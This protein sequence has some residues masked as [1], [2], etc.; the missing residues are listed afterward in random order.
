MDWVELD[1]AGP[2]AP[3]GLAP[4]VLAAGVFALAFVVG[5]S[6]PAALAWSAGVAVAQAVWFAVDPFAT[7]HASGELV[8]L[9]L[10]SAAVVAASFRRV[11]L[12]PMLFLLGLLFKGAALFHPSHWYPD[13]RLHRRYVEAF[14]AAE[15][16]LL[17]RGI[18]AQIAS[19]TAYA[20]ELAGKGYAFPYSPLFYVPFAALDQDARELERTMK[21]AGLLMAAVELPLVYL[22]A[23]SVLGAGAA[24]W[25]AGLVWFLPPVASRMLYAQW[26]TLAGHLIDLLL[27]AAALALAR[28]P[29]TA[30]P[31]LRYA[32][33]GL[34]TCL[35]YISSLFH[36]SVLTT[37]LSALHPRQA[38][39]WLALGVAVGL[40]VI[41]ALYLP[42]VR[43]VVSEVLPAVRAGT[44]L[45]GEGSA[46]P[47]LSDVL[48]RV[49]AFYGYG[50]PALAVA[51]LALVRDRGASF[52]FLAAYGL[53]FVVLLALRA[54]SGAF[55]D[56]KELVFVGP[57]V[58]MAAGTSLESLAAR[59]ASGR[60]AAWLVAIGLAGFGL[61]TL[62]GYAVQHT[63]LVGLD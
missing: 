10:A 46:R 23:R 54:S 6:L 57:F 36:F 25:A 51:G 3:M 45:L 24:L 50:L 11:R 26:P 48:V 2:L 39:R 49:P 62:A 31:A 56:L 5:Y 53:A 40:A 13:V 32:G 47:E 9:A 35:L 7:T 59:G 19:G 34:A 14:R 12:L 52:R 15:G 22:L 4:F 58:A 60:W 30:A 17:E 21:R 38:L 44:P 63:A 37:T 42:F 18:E 27:L 41:A 8:I 1:G 43:L 33:A 61:T 16:G 20:R 29:S 55:K 28:S